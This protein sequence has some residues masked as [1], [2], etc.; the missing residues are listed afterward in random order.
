MKRVSSLLLVSLVAACTHAPPPAVAP[1]TLATPTTPSLTDGVH[2][3]DSVLFR[4][5]APACN[6][7][8][9]ADTAR[10]RRVSLEVTVVGGL[11]RRFVRKRSGGSLD[12]TGDLGTAATDYDYDG[13]R[14]RG[15]VMR[16]VGGMV[17]GKT[18]YEEGGAL[19]NYEN[20]LGE[21]RRLAGTLATRA[22]L[23]ESPEGFIDGITY[24]DEANRKV[25]GPDGAHE[26]RR[27]L[28]AFGETLVT[29][30][31][32]AQGKP[33]RGNDGWHEQREEYDARGCV[34]RRA[35]FGVDGEPTTYGYEQSV[36]AYTC[37]RWG[38]TTR[39]EFFDVQGR[40]TVNSLGVASWTQAFDEHGNPVEDVDFGLDGQRSMGASDFAVARN[41][42]DDRGRQLSRAYF[43]PT[44]IPVMRRSGY[45]R[46]EYRWNDDGRM[47]EIR[48]YDDAGRP[49]HP[50]HD[51]RVH[52]W[53]YVYDRRG[54][55]VG[56]RTVGDDG[57]PTPDRTGVDARAFD[58]DDANRR[59]EARSYRD[60]RLH[61]ERD[62]YARVVLTPTKDGSPP[63]RAYFAA[64]GSPV[65]LL[66]CKA[67]M[68][69]FDGVKGT[70]VTVRTRDEAKARAE[71]ARRQLLG[72]ARI[73]D[74]AKALDDTHS[75]EETHMAKGRRFAALDVALEKTPVDGI[76]E[77]VE[78][79]NGFFV[80][81]RI[82]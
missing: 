37:D 31:F 32:D 52:G 25:A 28:N 75:V 38:R 41:R 17:V 4:N 8:F 19:A 73:E 69:A 63:K 43:G 40:T 80:M 10:H 36:I 62:G 1:T 22:R 2:A 68:I 65:T 70:V 54:R 56:E 46:V 33:Q 47:T 39:Y 26:L 16:D 66:G 55:Q 81:Q 42:Y 35:A 11:I 14:A 48:Y 72:G 5:G 79:E 21:P 61:D 64:D 29:R 15:A 59:I 23:H 49:A 24:F 12:P 20:A 60:S 51:A 27:T 76:S 13:K 45:S 78:T 53:S 7:L 44:G 74:V 67:L 34:T 82:P 71:E 30:Y 9:D 3:C 58:Y 57:K 18:R 6:R 77:V 50:F